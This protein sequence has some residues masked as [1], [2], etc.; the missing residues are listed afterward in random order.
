MSPLAGPDAVARL[1]ALVRASAPRLGVGGAAPTRLVL[2][3]GPAGSGKTTLADRLAAELAGGHSGQ[4]G[5]QGPPQVL[6]ADDMYEGWGGLP[7]LDEVLVAQVLAPLVRGDDGGF[8]RWDWAADARAEHVRVPA[9]QPLLIVEGV[10]VGMRLA[11]AHAS[12]MV[13]VEAP[14]PLRRARGLERDGDELRD[15]WDRWQRAEDAFLDGEGT[16]AAADVHVDG[17]HPW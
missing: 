6:H 13:W 1:A 2:I 15:E 8:R 11:R 7:T 9:G 16:R 10:G 17:S 14:A 4:P 12:V 3:D 5:H